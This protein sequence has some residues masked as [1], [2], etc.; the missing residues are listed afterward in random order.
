MR[1]LGLELSCV[2]NVLHY[3]W[4][5]T[6][7]YLPPKFKFWATSVPA[8]TTYKQQWGVI[9]ACGTFLAFR[10]YSCLDS[11]TH[12]SH[13]CCDF[14]SDASE[15]PWGS[16]SDHPARSNNTALS[17]KLKLIRKEQGSSGCSRQENQLITPQKQ[18][19]SKSILFS[20]NRH[21]N[22]FL[23]FHV[24][25]PEVPGIAGSGIPILEVQFSSLLPPLHCTHHN[26]PSIT[27]KKDLSKIKESLL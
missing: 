26:W 11:Q 27:A 21:P 4:N 6:V 10:F 9:I 2:N 23:F 8:P 24:S 15:G 14:H 3:L 1:H 20:Y 22:A 7:S 19:T 18:E 17:V 12:R 16:M 5:A 13:W 25:L